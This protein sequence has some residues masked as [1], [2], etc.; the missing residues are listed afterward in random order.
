MRDPERSGDLDWVRYNAQ[1]YE[2]RVT[3]P[4]AAAALE[5]LGG[6][7][8]IL[9]ISVAGYVAAVLALFA[10]LLLRFRLGIAAVV[11]AATIV[12]PA[13][14]SHST[15][16]LTDSWGLALET[17]AF[18][19]GILVLDRGPRWLPAW[20]AALLVLSFTRD[21]AWIPILAA[22]FLTLHL[23][24]RLSL[25]M[26]GTGLAAAVPALLA[27]ATPLR[28]LLAMMLNDFRPL[29][30]A[31]WGF[32][33]ERYPGALVDLVQANGGFVRDGAW[34]SAAYLAVGIALLFLLARGARGSH[35]ATL[36]KGGAIAGLAYVLVVPIFSAFRLELVCVPM[37][38][39]GLALGAERLS[40]ALAPQLERVRIRLNTRA[41]EAGVA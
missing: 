30:D 1:F 2:R 19:A 38:A 24:S 22:A 13:L 18:A 29:P 40:E 37:A 27:F 5:P 39:F 16:P 28:E 6:E 33:A 11:T 7:R 21:S 15:F 9:N 23:R 14:T 34:Y 31:S 41:R 4:A 12:L 35:A 3:V 17:A 26:L 10:L 25:A 32:I 20:G 8:T 36:L